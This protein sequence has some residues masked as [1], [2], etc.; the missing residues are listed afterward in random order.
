[1]SGRIPHYKYCPVCK[2]KIPVQA[3]ICLYCEEPLLPPDDPADS[4]FGEAILITSVHPDGEAFIDLVEGAEGES[5][6]EEICEREYDPE[7]D[8]GEEWKPKR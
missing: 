4:P 3:I 6:I 7:D 5:G 8:A 1:M 2:S